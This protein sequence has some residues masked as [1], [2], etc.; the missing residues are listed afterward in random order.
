M[1]KNGKQLRGIAILTTSVHYM[2]V[3]SL[4]GWGEEKAVNMKIPKGFIEIENQ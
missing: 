3:L 1:A 4:I 2:I